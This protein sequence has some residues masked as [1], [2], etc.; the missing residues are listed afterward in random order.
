M[1]LIFNILFSILFTIQVLA[2]DKV[3]IHP[4][5]NYIDGANIGVSSGGIDYLE[6]KELLNAEFSYDNSKLLNLGISS[7]MHW[8]K[9]TVKNTSEEVYLSLKIP[10]SYLDRVILYDSIEFGSMHKIE[11]GEF[12]PF[13][14]KDNKLPYPNFEIKINKNETR[15]LFLQVQSH[16]QL[17]FPLR[18]QSLN[19][20]DDTRHF[21]FIGLFFGV[22]M[23]MFLYNFILF[24]NTKNKT[25]LYYVLYLLAVF[26]TQSCV[27]GLSHFL[28]PSSPFLLDASFYFGTGF[29]GILG[30]LFIYDFLNVAEEQPKTRPV[31]IFF[32]IS[33][34]IS[35]VLAVF[36]MY[37]LC[38]IMLQINGVFI[39]VFLLYLGIKSIFSG[40]IIARYFVIAWSAFLTGVIIFVLK[41]YNLVPFNYFTLFIMPIGAM[42]ETVLLSVAL[43]HQ[44]NILKK[45]NELAHKRVVEEVQKNEELV[46]N[47]NAT[48]EEKVKVRTSEL[49][50]ALDDLKSTQSQLVQSE[51]MASL[52]VLTAGIA[53]EINNPINFVTANVIPL[54]ENIDDINNLLNE[55]K[56][57][58]I[59]DLENELLRI[60][61]LENKMDL[62]YTVQETKQLINGIEEGARRTHS[63]VDGLKTFSQ[64]DA[65]Q[66]AFADIN[67]GIHSTISVLKSRLNSVQVELDLEENIP[68]VNC[69]IG[70]INQVVL[71]LLNNAIDALDEKYG[72][73]SKRSKL[74]IRSYSQKDSL[75][76][77]VSDNAN[78]MSKD[79]QGK[80]MEPFFTT[81]EV[82][83][84]TGLGLSISYS[85][86]EDHKGELLL[87]SIEG[88]GTTFTLVLP[89]LDVTV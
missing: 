80:I 78:G 5:D 58:D 27:V 8:M 82:G 36:G 70:K 37:S 25:Y 76:I 43:A 2:T 40:K 69:Q 51:K 26:F 12:I 13:N 34:A 85:I 62:S 14:E 71:N 79:I 45:D 73:N 83:K 64:G 67:K 56:N 52:G 29:V 59:N 41:D 32:Y 48:L 6:S 42:I 66:K 54:R 81:K 86:I 11:N 65:G 9:L 10:V 84:G 15:I 1:K 18:I 68:L 89:K 57:I 35:L 61:E 87:E 49:Q 60:A 74:G 38:Y 3:I 44:I 75:K 7:K 77:S 72:A 50:Q 46:L 16:E 30:S 53:H 24:V 4:S 33:Y 19:T 31:R 22:F 20:T 55:Y 39:S 21:L 88:E 17:I 23:A 28:F 63:I 47:Q